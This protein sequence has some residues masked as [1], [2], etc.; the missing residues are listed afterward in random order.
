MPWSPDYAAERGQKNSSSPNRAS[1][2]VNLG[3]YRRLIVDPID[4]RASFGTGVHDRLF[5]RRR[6]EHI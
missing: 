5:D 6:P 3:G 1:G 2:A 4:T